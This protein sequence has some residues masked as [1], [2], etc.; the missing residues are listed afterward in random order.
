MQHMGQGN[1]LRTKVQAPHTDRAPG[2]AGPISGIS[3]AAT[4]AMVGWTLAAPFVS[5]RV[6]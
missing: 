1:A 4:T 2:Q 5:A 6:V 3:K